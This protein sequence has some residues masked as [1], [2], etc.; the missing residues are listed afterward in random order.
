MKKTLRDR[1]AALATMNLPALREEHRRVFGKEPVSAHRQFLFRQI[2]SRLQANEEGWQ[3]DE[4]ETTALVKW[5]TTE[6]TPQNTR[7]G[8]SLMFMTPGAIGA[9]GNI[10]GQCVQ[11]T[12]PGTN[13]W[14][15]TSMLHFSPSPPRLRSA[16]PRPLWY[17]DIGP[18]AQLPPQ[19]S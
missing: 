13:S 17:S 9:V 4:A 14:T 1:I 15:A 16:N 2:A 18:L 10:H 3:P 19:A 8:S 5:P 6:Q 11:L 12:G 7:I